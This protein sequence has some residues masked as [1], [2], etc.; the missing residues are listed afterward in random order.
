MYLKQETTTLLINGPE[1]PT[2]KF[3]F[4]QYYSQFGPN[5]QIKDR[6]YFRLYSI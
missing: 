3:K 5:R 4:C 1:T 2:A 6:Q